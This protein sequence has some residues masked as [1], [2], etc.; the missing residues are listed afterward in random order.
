MAAGHNTL[1]KNQLHI[2]KRCSILVCA[3]TRIAL[4]ASIKEACGLSPNIQQTAQRTLPNC[5]K[6][7]KVP[8]TVSL[9][10]TKRTL[11]RLNW[12]RQPFVGGKAPRMNGYHL[13]DVTK[14]ALGMDSIIGIELKSF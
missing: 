2:G 3:L 8:S 12:I 7:L 4:E 1:Q 10:N 5:L 13:D 11:N 9:E 6:F 14:I